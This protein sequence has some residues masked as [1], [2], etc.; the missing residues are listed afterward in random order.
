MWEKVLVGIAISVIAVC[1]LVLIGAAVFS[2][3]QDPPCTGYTCPPGMTVIPYYAYRS[4]T[5]CLCS[6]A[7]PRRDK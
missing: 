6:A 4:E 2:D 1:L 5:V 3:K 7:P